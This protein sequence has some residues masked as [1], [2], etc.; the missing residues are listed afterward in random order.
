MNSK[1][2]HIWACDKTIF[3]PEILTQKKQTNETMRIFRKILQ[4]SRQQEI[5]RI[6]LFKYYTE[7]DKWKFGQNC[8]YYDRNLPFR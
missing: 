3:R 4:F 7:K 8:H 1:V 2:I 5:Q 6:K